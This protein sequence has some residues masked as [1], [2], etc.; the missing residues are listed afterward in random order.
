MRKNVGQQVENSGGAMPAEHIHAMLG[1]QEEVAA[2]ARMVGN[3]RALPGGAHKLA[4]QRVPV[5]MEP[6]IV[7]VVSLFNDK[8]AEKGTTI[9]INP[10]PA[11]IWALADEDKLAQV[12]TTLLGNSVAFTNSGSIDVTVTGRGQEVDIMIEDP[13]AHFDK[14]EQQF[15]FRRDKGMV[16]RKLDGRRGPAMGLL[17][18]G[19]IIGAHGGK[20]WVETVMDTRNRFTVTLPRTSPSRA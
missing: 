9:R 1:L 4:L 5:N 12:L 7:Q 17:I 2:L 16:L 15:I 14:A 10:P 20:I 13:G 18:A 6:L 19:E 3:L 11:D 8:A